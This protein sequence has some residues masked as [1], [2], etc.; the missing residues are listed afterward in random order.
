MFSPCSRLCAANRKC[1]PVLS[2]GH[3]VMDAISS[4][5]HPWC[6]SCVFLVSEFLPV[7][8]QISAAHTFWFYYSV[9]WQQEPGRLSL[10]SFYLKTQVSCLVPGFFPSPRLYLELLL[11]TV[12]QRKDLKFKHTILNISTWTQT[13]YLFVFT[14]RVNGGIDIHVENGCGAFPSM[15]IQV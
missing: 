1:S 11:E 5:D 7:F 12:I 3:S 9:A 15:P 14:H 2:H 10:S 8:L 13:W 4:E 6:C